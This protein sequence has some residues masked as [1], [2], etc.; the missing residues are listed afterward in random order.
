MN[1]TPVTFGDA[2]PKLGVVTEPA[3]AGETRVAAILLN[4]GVVHRVGPG[5]LTVRLARQLAARGLLAA[6]FDHGGIGDSPLRRDRLTW[7]EATVAETREVMDS[8]AASHGVERFLLVGLC[9]GAVTAF[10]VALEDERVAGLV[11][12]NGQGLDASLDWNTFVKNRGWAR[13]Y[14]SRSLWRADSWKRA[15]TGRIQYRRLVGVLGRAVLHK[16]RP[17]KDVTEIT[18]RLGEQ[19]AELVARDVHML[20]VLSAGDHAEDYF[21]VVAGGRLA[22]LK[23]SGCFRVET[24]EG[25]D[26][27][28]SLMANQADLHRIVGGWAEEGWSR[29]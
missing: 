23:S 17:A 5:R 24:V 22:E 14:W 25:T 4:A 13:N 2:F 11:S 15:L 27:T 7:A 18:D 19:L 29:P 21:D 6:R 16:L 1:E 20:V 3:S 10:R 9:S 28:F 8:L 12:I 26:H